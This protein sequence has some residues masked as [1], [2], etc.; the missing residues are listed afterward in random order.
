M[1]K[2]KKKQLPQAGPFK[3]CACP[4]V[5]AVS[6]THAHLVR[7]KH[8]NH[9]QTLEAASCGWFRKTSQASSAS[10]PT[11]PPP[12][13]PPFPPRPSDGQGARALGPPAKSSAGLSDLASSVY[14]TFES[15]SSPRVYRRPTLNWCGQVGGMSWFLRRVPPS[16]DHNVVS[17][18]QDLAVLQR[19]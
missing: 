6:S 18:A 9:N 7:L 4:H 3:Y 13:A 11:P 14:C 5:P 16:Q 10:C 12:P 2:K 19:A 1:E 8:Y 15:H 17:L